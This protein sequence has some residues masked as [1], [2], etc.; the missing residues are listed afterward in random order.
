MLNWREMEGEEKYL[1]FYFVLVHLLHLYLDP[2]DLARQSLLSS[3]I[4]IL[5]SWLHLCHDSSFPPRRLGTLSVSVR[6]VLLL[7]SF[8]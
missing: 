4:D 1:Q 2:L 8:P 6:T 7:Q 5:V 3:I